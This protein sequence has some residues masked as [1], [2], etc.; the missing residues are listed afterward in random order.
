MDSELDPII[1][2]QHAAFTRRQARVAGF[3]RVTIVRRIERGTWICINDHVLR[4]AAAPVTE[5]QKVMA[6]VLSGGPDTVATA[7]TAL[8]LRGVRGFRLLPADAVT[9]RRP[10]R[11]ALPGVAETYR[12]AEEHRTEVDGIP[13]AT[14]A[15]A[16]FDLGARVRR[17]RLARAVDAAL[18]AKR[19]T[20]AELSAV[21][22][23]LAE[24]GR[25][26]SASLRAVVAERHGAYVAPTTNLEAAFLDLVRVRGLPEPERQVNL[27]GRLGWIG[28][29]D[30]LWRDERVVVE[31]DGG[32]YHD[33]LTDRADDERRD[34][35]LE[36]AG[37][38]VL[39]FS[40]LDVS[41]RPTSVMRTL[42][43]ALAIAAA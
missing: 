29:V 10:P 18:A 28:Q 20:I 8:A 21:L 14:V 9:A 41:I 36:S 4:L 40:D 17:P 3:H 1:A 30:F 11:W 31:T 13:T 33:S 23:D 5:H 19:V 27:G 2:R 22:D 39:R 6:V 35:A 43:R 26:G 16:L 15:R 12:L 42:S 25:S 34:R 37:W 7:S 24:H 32:A 38:V